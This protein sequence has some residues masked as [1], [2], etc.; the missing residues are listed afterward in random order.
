[1]RRFFE[2]KVAFAMLAILF[3]LACAWNLSHAGTLPVKV[4]SG[5]TMPPAPWEDFRLASGPTMP[6]APWE[7]L[8]IASGPT[9]PPAPWEDL[10][11]ASGPTMPP[12]PWEDLRVTG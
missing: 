3:A 2:N 7:D 9:M 6:P 5:P 1:M 8:R 4:G 11:I 12:A 10:R